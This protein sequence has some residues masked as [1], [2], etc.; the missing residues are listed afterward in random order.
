MNI[1]A[2]QWKKYAPLSGEELGRRLGIDGANA[3]RMIRKAKKDPELIG[4]DWFGGRPEPITL[5]K[6]IA[7][8]DL[9]HPHHHSKLWHN[10]LAFTDAFEPD[11]FVFG[12]DNQDLEVISHWVGN[13][14]RRVE[15]QRLKRDYTRFTKDVLAPIDDILGDDTE[16]IY[17]L[18][19]HEDWVEQYIDEHPEVEGFFEIRNNLPLDNWAV[20]DYGEVAKVG[21]LYFTHGTYINIH[22]AYKTAQVYARNVAYG[23]GHTYQAHTLTAPLDV[24]S[25][26]ATQL[27]CACKINPHYRRNHPNAWVNGFGVFYVQPN[28]NFSLYPVIAVDGSFTAPDGTFY[29]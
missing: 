1:T 27:P 22:N 23:H 10:I 20:Y 29:E 4:L 13:K 9:H 21:K 28:G 7:V 16:R 26:T 25:H 18:G 19:N 12:G 15:G 2:A 17:L 8:F 5:R 6:G 11:V 24:E 3:R 14:R